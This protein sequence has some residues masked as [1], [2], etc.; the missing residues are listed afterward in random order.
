MM[1]HFFLPVAICL[2][3]C[4]DA[5][6]PLVSSHFLGFTEKFKLHAA[7]KVNCN[8]DMTYHKFKSVELLEFTTDKN[9]RI[10]SYYVIDSADYTEAL[11]KEMNDWFYIQSC[12]YVTGDNLSFYDFTFHGQ[13]YIGKE[14]TQCS[15]MYGGDECADGKRNLFKILGEMGVRKIER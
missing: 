10:C 4:G 9:E 14:C 2:C 12:S 8:V 13:I 1:K 7:T 5:Q 6:I 11:R 3:I 15:T